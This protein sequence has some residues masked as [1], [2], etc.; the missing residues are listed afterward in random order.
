MDPERQQH[1]GRSIFD[2]VANNDCSRKSNL[3]GV[4]YRAMLLAS[5]LAS[6]WTAR[7]ENRAIESERAS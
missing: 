4:Y 7:S 2:G 3:F 6:D 5:E 1:T